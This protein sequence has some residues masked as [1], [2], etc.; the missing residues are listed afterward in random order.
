MCLG[1][2]ERVERKCNFRLNS[3]C[4][5]QGEPGNVARQHRRLERP[6]LQLLG[7]TGICPLTKLLTVSQ[8]STTNIINKSV[9]SGSPD[10]LGVRYMLS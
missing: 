10:L 7:P 9:R 1:K 6:G 2:R 5:G 4:R 8:T 3:G